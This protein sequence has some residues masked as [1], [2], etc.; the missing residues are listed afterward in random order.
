MAASQ[1]QTVNAD[2]RISYHHQIETKNSLEKFIPGFGCVRS[3]Y[4][5]LLARE[6]A[7]C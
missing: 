1:Y 3:V 2:Y 7:L 5:G 6:S 4:G